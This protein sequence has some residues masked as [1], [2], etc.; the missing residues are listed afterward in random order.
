MLDARF[1]NVHSYFFCVKYYAKKI[2]LVNL[3]EQKS[4]GSNFQPSIFN[5]KDRAPAA[6]IWYRT[7]GI[8]HH[9]M[10]LFNLDIH[11]VMQ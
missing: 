3:F 8:E 2:N 5:I 10:S 9:P 11:P 4:T 1:L 6:D 7:S